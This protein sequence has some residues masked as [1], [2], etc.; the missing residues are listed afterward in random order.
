MGEF[1]I[2]N[3]TGEELVRFHQKLGAPTLK[4]FDHFAYNGNYKQFCV[5]KDGLPIAYGFL[6]RM[7]HLRKQ[8]VCVLGMVVADTWQD[9][10]V[11]TLLGKHMVNWARGEGY[12]KIA[13]G[14]YRDNTRAIRFYEKLG[15]VKEGIL[16]NE[17]LCDD[18]YRH[19]VTM[20]YHL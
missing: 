14:V 11:G 3:I 9:K 1:E 6:R 7:L 2:T 12:K 10:G 16:V 15:F 8:H 17:E 13:L 20:A 5:R 19:M 4:Y 18:G